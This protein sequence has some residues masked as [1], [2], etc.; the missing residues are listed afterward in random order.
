[1]KDPFNSNRPPKE[2]QR[3]YS[4]HAVASAFLYIRNHSN[5]AG[6]EAQ[7]LTILQHPS[8]RGREDE[9]AQS[10]LEIMRQSLPGSA[11]RCIAGETVMREAEIL[12][13]GGLEDKA[14][15]YASKVLTL[16]EDSS[17]DHIGLQA[18]AMQAERKLDLWMETHLPKPKAVPSPATTATPPCYDQWFIKT[19]FPELR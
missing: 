7:L 19:K 2:P 9:T 15:N 8:R 11:V 10:A 14:A 16:A 6:A 1:M 12:A 3:Y 18:L 4:S 13:Q 17:G 5:D